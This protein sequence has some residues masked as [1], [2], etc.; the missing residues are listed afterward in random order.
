M[1]CEGS[2]CEPLETTLSHQE[3][4][5]PVK[6][7]RCCQEPL[8]QTF[9]G[10]DKNH[11]VWSSLRLCRLR[12]WYFHCCGPDYSCGPGYSCSGSIPSLENST[13]HKNGKKKV[14]ER[15]KKKSK[16]PLWLS[17]KEPDR[18]LWGGGFHPWPPSVGKGPGISMSYGVGHKGSL[19]LALL[20]LCCRPAA[21][22]LIRL[23]ARE[24]PYATG[25][26]LKIK[27]K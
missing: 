11:G 21:V 2:S 6:E 25:L 1:P 14:K 13:C 9:K 22:L 26:A 16:F 3:R 10:K 4:G 8:P 15:K 12:I 24:L 19:D 18:Y 20:W 5:T 17:Y 27:I 7:T 23:I